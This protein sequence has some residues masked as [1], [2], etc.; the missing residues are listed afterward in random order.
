MTNTILSSL[1][2]QLADAVARVA[3]AVVQVQGRRRP[4]SGLVFADGLVLT[5]AR[6]LGRDDRVTVRTGDGRSCE[7]ELAGWDPATGLAVLRVA[8]LNVAP[9]EAAPEPP[10]VGHFVLA[11]GR[12]WSNAVSASTGIVAVIGGPLRTGRRRSIE[13]VIRTTAPLHEGFAGGP[14]LDASGRVVGISTGV[15]IRGFEV[16]I[17][18]AIAWK[19][20][21]NVRKEGRPAR[22]FLGIAGQTVRLSPRQRGANGPEQALLV[23][24]VTEDSPADRAGLLVG[25]IVVTF[26]GRPVHAS[27]DLLDLLTDSTVGRAV[28]LAVL[29]GGVR[30]ELTLTPAAR[31]QRER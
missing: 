10:R 3:P 27:E 26:D 25:D 16:A 28:V 30:H 19:T 12:S 24:G 29:R 21:E 31:E 15:A 18:A 13:Q 4:I 8:G 2:S 11:V 17:P 6:V 23:V 22:G 9:A 14:L 20:A 7:T 5:S 1:S